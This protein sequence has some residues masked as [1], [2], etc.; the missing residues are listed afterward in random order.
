[1]PGSLLSPI[2]AIKVGHFACQ[3][4]AKHCKQL[5]GHPLQAATRTA[6]GHCSDQQCSSQHLGQVI[7]QSA[8]QS[9]KVALQHCRTHLLWDPP[10]PHL[11]DVTAVVCAGVV[12]QLCRHVCQAPGLLGSG[13][14]SAGGRVGMVST[15]ALQH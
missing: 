14:A 10:M 6:W 12:V 9:L 5:H 15:P 2:A 11:Q 7:P 8:H 13:T 3:L 1:M 4:L